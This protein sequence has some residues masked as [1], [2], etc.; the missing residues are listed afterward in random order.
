MHKLEEIRIRCG[1][2]YNDLSRLAGGSASGANKSA[3][4]KLCLGTADPRQVQSLQP[5]LVQA[6]EK[7]LPTKGIPANELNN[8]S[9]NQKESMTQ[10]EPRTV[11][12]EQALLH[13]GLNRDPFRPPRSADDVFMTPHL[14]NVVKAVSDAVYYQELRAVIGQVGAGKT[15]VRQL[16]Q[17]KL[18]GG[19]IRLIWP[20]ATDMRFVSVKNIETA[21]LDHFEETDC[22]NNTRR[23][24]K[25]IR[26][27]EREF[28]KG[29]RC[30][31]CF[32]EAHDLPDR[33]LL[34]IK[35]FYEMGYG[36]FRYLGILM[37]GQQHLY[38]RL[39]RNV[40]FREIFMRM[41][42]STVRPFDTRQAVDYVRFRV[43]R[44]G[45]NPDLLAPDVITRF[46]QPN[47]TPLSIGNFAAAAI[48]AALETAIAADEKVI[49]VDL[50]ESAGFFERSS[51]TKLV[52]R[53][54]A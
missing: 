38:S 52:A 8:V 39:E 19:N 21:I 9:P 40:H 13:F 32:D 1:L 47:A 25:L 45:G 17:D 5:L 10:M 54:I 50:L 42:F 44:A 51:E 30:T 20:M 46:V 49:T 18:F 22:A 29:V 36:F 37:F 11:L 24:Q 7:F 3:V 31:I 43:Q 34:K 15:V 12:T 14:Q 6:L 35:D 16:L 41:D 28:K 23:H 26:V 2:S 27:L 33:T 4:R 48:M 53:K